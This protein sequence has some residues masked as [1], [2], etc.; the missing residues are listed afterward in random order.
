[1]LKFVICNA[2]LIDASGIMLAAQALLANFDIKQPVK[3]IEMQST[4]P[5]ANQLV[6][7]FTISLLEGVCFPFI[8]IHN[9]SAIAATLK[10]IHCIDAGKEFG[11]VVSGSKFITQKFIPKNSSWLDWNQWQEKKKD[12]TVSKI[13]KFV[14][15]FDGD[16]AEE[17]KQILSTQS[18]ATIGNECR[19]LMSILSGNSD[20]KDAISIYLEQMKQIFHL[21]E[22]RVESI[23]SSKYWRNEL[24]LMVKLGPYDNDPQEKIKNHINQLYKEFSKFNEL[25]GRGLLF[26]LL[27]AYKLMAR[28]QAC[29]EE[30]ALICS[31]RCF[32]LT[33]V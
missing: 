3:F 24:C 4:T 10:A 18:L 6:D 29:A 12:A 32:C 17:L 22:N 13:F 25:I 19:K 2:D 31:I 8:K 5:S 7:I 14:A 23:F 20:K 21:K 30:F 27:E 9:P 26:H 1:M 33:N 15:Q 11:I 16:M 28:N